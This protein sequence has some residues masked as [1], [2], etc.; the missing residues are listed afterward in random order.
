MAFLL[1][2]DGSN[3]PLEVQRWQYFLLRMGISQAGRIDGQF[4]LKTEEATKFFQ[5]QNGLTINGKLDAPTLAV[6][7]GM[8]Y[9]VVP[10]DF[11]EGLGDENFPPKPP[12]THSPTNDERNDG[13]G[14]Y[15]FKQLALANRADPDE[16]VIQGDCDDTV[17]NWRN[18]FIATVTISQPI[19]ANGFNKRITGHKAVLPHWVRLF[20]RWEELDLLHLIRNFDGDFSPRYKRGQSPGNGSHGTRS[21]RNVDALSNHAF[22]SAMDINASDN[23]FGSMPALLPGRGCVRQLV[24]P[25]SELGFF[26]GG[27]FSSTKDGMHFEFADFANL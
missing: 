19:F 23:G 4:G 3:F 12:G 8:G 22:G 13:L 24:V 17:A 20:E 27:Y 14:C 1:R 10:D 9:S 2:R 11:Y 16:I 18:E 26:W 25:A 7:A 21:S 6:A 5:I 15:K